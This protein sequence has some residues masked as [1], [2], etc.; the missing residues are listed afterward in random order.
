MRQSSLEAHEAI[1]PQKEDHYSLIKKAMRRIR[2]PAMSKLIAGFCPELDYHAVAR[3]LSEMEKRGMVRV[4]G[5]MPN[6]KNRPLLWEL[7]E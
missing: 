6:V 1:K 2:K 5:R 7:N 3:R 4:V